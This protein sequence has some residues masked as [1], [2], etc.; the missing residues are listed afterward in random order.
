MAEPSPCL[1]PVER[2]MQILPHRFP[3]IMID[4]VEEVIPERP[5]GRSVLG[6]KSVVRKNVTVNEPYFTGHF[7]YRKVMPGV[8]QIESMAQ[9]GGIA[10]YNPDDPEG[11]EVLITGVNGAKFRKQVVPG[12]TMIIRSVVKKERLLKNKTSVVVLDCK[13]YVD[14]ELVSEVELLAYIQPRMTI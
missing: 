11:Y 7:P 10:C 4:R 6:R 8:L 9:A 12:D 2:I 13:A 3:F 1:Y 5:N 14:D